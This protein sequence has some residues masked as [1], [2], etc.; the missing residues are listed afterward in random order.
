[1]C[2][3][4]SILNILKPT[5]DIWYCWK[6]TESA[7]KWPKPRPPWLLFLG[8]STY[9]ATLGL[10]KFVT[11][12]APQKWLK[13]L[14][15]KCCNKPLELNKSTC[16]LVAQG[17]KGWHQHQSESQNAR[18]G[19]IQKIYSC[20]DLLPFGGKGCFYC[21]KSMANFYCD[22]EWVVGLGRKVLF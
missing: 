20:W 5:K 4:S 2:D 14:S 3:F 9:H 17:G 18:K 7:K 16:M 1:M 13:P 22:H 19:Y 21:F 11:L 8:L 6:Q 15:R 12:G 10:E